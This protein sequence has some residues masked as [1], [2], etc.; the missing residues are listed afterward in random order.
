MHNQ[1][2]ILSKILRK[3]SPGDNGIGAAEVMTC[4]TNSSME[5]CLINNQGLIEHLECP[6]FPIELKL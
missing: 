5:N 2:A 4:S 1:P 3:P 6:N